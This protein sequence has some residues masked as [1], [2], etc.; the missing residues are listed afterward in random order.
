MAETKKETSLSQPRKRAAQTARKPQPKTA[1]AKM[2]A[3][4]RRG[5]QSPAPRAPKAATP[6]KT[7][8]QAMKMAQETA[9]AASEA[10]R[11]LSGAL[12]PAQDKQTGR[13]AAKKT[14]RQKKQPDYQKHHQ[15]NI[16][17]S[18]LNPKPG[19]RQYQLFPSPLLI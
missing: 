10:V 18:T 2:P 16:Q 3:A 12:L 13:Q 6:R 1:A 11:S 19:I 8:Q 17:E 15:D 4:R 7:A 5:S 14:V 9:K